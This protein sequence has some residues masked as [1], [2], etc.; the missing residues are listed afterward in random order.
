MYDRG[1]SNGPTV[2]KTTSLR[3]RHVFLLYHFLCLNSSVVDYTLWPF[4]VDTHVYPPFRKKPDG[5]I[6]DSY[7]TT[8]RCYPEVPEVLEKLH[9]EGYALA[10]ASRTPEIEAA[11][12]LMS[13]FGWE[14]Y[15]KYKQIFPG[16]K[17]AHFNK[18]KEQSGLDFSEMMFFD[19]ENRNI[20]DVNELG[21]TAV[22]VKNGVSKKVVDDAIQEFVSNKRKQS[23][24]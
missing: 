7:G 22:L 9:C 1:A 11:K 10:V 5:K 4:W 24:P 19:D 16:C 18:I 6:L 12:Q 21:V 2:P 23:V 14:K 20:R 17:V 13:L 8:I 3:P 15:F